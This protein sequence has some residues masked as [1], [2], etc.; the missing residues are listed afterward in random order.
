MNK[1]KEIVLSW[2]L[3]IVNG[4]DENV[5]SVRIILTEDIFT[6]N[7]HTIA[8]ALSNIVKPIAYTII[9]LCFL[10]EFLKITINMDV[11]KWEFGLK[12]FFKLVFAKACIDISAQ[13]MEAIYFTAVE[14]ITKMSQP[15]GAGSVST[16]FG[17]NAA[18]KFNELLQTCTWYEALGYVCTLVLPFLIVMLVGLAVKVIAYA[19]M[20]ELMVYIAIAPLPCSF[21]PLEDGGG[22]RI[23]KKFFLNFASVCLHGVFIIISIQLFNI[24]CNEQLDAAITNSAEMGTASNVMLLASLVLI[25]AVTKSGSWAKQVLD[26]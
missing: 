3:S 19:R 18:V 11:L 7:V 25:L 17:A 20:F 8:M 6:G 21:L 26:V 15:I 4:F 9:G 10:I 23:P 2:I 14:W 12:C 22:S 16:S 5:N 13:L 24:I 1:F